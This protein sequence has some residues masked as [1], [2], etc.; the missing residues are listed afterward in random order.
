MIN[1]ELKTIYKIAQDHYCL[2][3]TSQKSPTIT[4]GKNCKLINENLV[5]INKTPLIACASVKKIRNNY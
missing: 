2:V 5:K 4:F 3:L 1:P